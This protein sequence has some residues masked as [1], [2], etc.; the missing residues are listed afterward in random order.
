MA[1]MQMH[2]AVAIDW[3]TMMRKHYAQACRVIKHRMPRGLRAKYDPEDFVGDAIVELISN[4]AR[5]VV[6]APDMLILIANRR[7]IDAARSPRSR[8][9]PLNEH[10]IDRQP[11]VALKDDAAVLREWM[12]CRAGNSSDRAVVDLRCQGHIAGNRRAY[13]PRIADGSTIL[14]EFHRSQ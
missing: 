1:E 10:A 6:F 14:Q 13:W 3:A 7:M 12:L 2:P 9:M 8:M 11:S 5:F 4:R